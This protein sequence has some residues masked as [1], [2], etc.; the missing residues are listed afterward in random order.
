MQSRRN[1]LRNSS[2]LSATL[3]IAP[4]LF[5]ESCSFDKRKVGLQL[6]TV[7]DAM[8]KDPAGTL[9]RVA[10]IGYKEVEA[11]TYTGT[12]LFYGLGTREVG[13]W[14]LEQQAAQRLCHEG[15]AD[16]VLSTT[17]HRLD[18]S[19]AER[20]IRFSRTVGRAQPCLP[21]HRSL[22]R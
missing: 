13:R 17:R 5:G 9:S 2:L 19:R 14:Q 12:E 11:A 16:D 7:R 20:R 1:F 21:E 6:Y 22:Q 8:A 15:T 3:L 4:S 18:S 10:E